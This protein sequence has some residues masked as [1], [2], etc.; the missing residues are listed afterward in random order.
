MPLVRTRVWTERRK[1]LGNLVPAVF[2][3]VPALIGLI[4][5]VIQG[6]LLGPGLAL[7]VF[8]TLAGWAAT[9]W[10]GFYQ[11]AQMRQELAAL[12]LARGETLDRAVFVGMA[13]PRHSGILDAHEDVGF[14]VL[15]AD[16][17]RY[18]GENRTIEIFRNDIGRIRMR[19]NV[20]S[21]IGLGGWVAV[22]GMVQGSPIRV[23]FEPREHPTMF[24][25]ARSRR[26]LLQRL[27]EWRRLVGPSG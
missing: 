4:V 14:L 15:K 9:G 19:G 7:L 20:H 23:L 27:E 3:A 17:L 8:A 26:P 11:N 6:N 16:R 18:V 21:L 5:I 24:Q 1:A 22:E 2:W 12:L 10:F 25:N 13:T